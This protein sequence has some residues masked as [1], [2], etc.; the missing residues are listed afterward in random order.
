MKKKS[1]IRHCL[2]HINGNRIFWFY[3]QII[4]KYACNYGPFTVQCTCNQMYFAH[5]WTTYYA[6]PSVVYCS[7]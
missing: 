3:V 4:K 6:S 5:N 1:S 7:L 2:N